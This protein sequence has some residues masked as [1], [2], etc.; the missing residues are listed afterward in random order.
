MAR[1]FKRKDDEEEK[2]RQQ[3]EAEEASSSS[4]S[5]PV[6]VGDSGAAD[7]VKHL[8]NVPESKKKWKDDTPP[9]AQA[10]PAA[11]PTP[12][13]APIEEPVIP[14]A[15]KPQ[16]F[17]AVKT[18]KNTYDFSWADD[19]SDQQRMVARIDMAH[20]P[21]MLAAYDD[22]ITGKGYVQDFQREEGEWEVLDRLKK[23]GLVDYTGKQYDLLHTDFSGLLN[24]VRMIPDTITR[25]AAYSDLKKLTKVK[26]GR[27]EEYT[28][29]GS[30]PGYLDTADMPE[31]DYD[32]FVKGVAGMFYRAGGYEKQN[33]KTYLK[34]YDEIT[35]ELSGLTDIQKHW[36]KKALDEAYREQT[37]LYPDVYEARKLAEGEKPQK[38]IS[39]PD[40]KPGRLESNGDTFSDILEWGKDLFGIGEEKPEPH[41][42]MPQAAP[43]PMG[44]PAPTPTPEPP[45]APE[46]QGPARQIPPTEEPDIILMEARRIGPKPESEPAAPE[47]QGP[48]QQEPAEPDPLTLDEQM[49]ARAAEKPEEPAKEQPA[50][51][52]VHLVDD[53]SGAIE[54]ARTG[55]YEQLDAATQ[56]E[57]QRFYDEAGP[58]TRIALGELAPELYKEYQTGNAPADYLYLQNAGMLGSTLAQYVLQIGGEDFPVELYGDAVMELARIT[59][60]AENDPTITPE[61]LQLDNRY[62]LYLRNHPDELA[63]LVNVFD[64]LAGMRSDAEANDVRLQELKAQELENARYAVSIGQANA[65]QKA[66]VLENAPDMDS[67]MAYRDRTYADMAQEL[68]E[69]FMDSSA[70]WGEDIGGWFNST[71][72]KM[73]RARGVKDLEDSESE[74]ELLLNN[75]ME[76]LLMQDMRMAAAV[77]Q[78]LETYYKKQGGMNLE[79]IAQRASAEILNIGAQTNEEELT[80]VSQSVAE[81]T[82]KVGLGVKNTVELTAMSG[83]GQV[84]EGALETV[85]MVASATDTPRDVA[86]TTTDF[87][88]LYGPFYGPT[89]CAKQQR[90]LAESGKLPE[91][92]SKSIIEYLDNGGDPYQLGIHPED[93]GGTINA[94]AETQ[95]R[96][97]YYQQMVESYATEGEAKFFE[98]GSGTV[99]NG[100]LMTA[101]AIGSAVLGPAA[102]GAAPFLAM[103]GTYGV[104][105]QGSYMQ[106][107]MSKGYTLKESLALSEAKVSS[108]ALAN[109]VSLGHLSGQLA[110]YSAWLNKGLTKLGGAKNPSVIRTFYESAKRFAVPLAKDLA[111]EVVKDPILEG[112][113]GEAA[114][115]AVATVIEDQREGKEIG[116]GTAVRAAVTGVLAG[117]ESV[118]GTIEAT[119]EDAPNA[120][121]ATLPIALLGAG[122]EYIKGSDSYKAAQNLMNH[123]SAATAAQFSDA[124]TKDAQDERWVDAI[125]AE[126]KQAEIEQTAAANLVFSPEPTLYNKAQKTREQAN[127]HK[128]TLDASTAANKQ[129]V[130]TIVEMQ[131]KLDAGDV[132]PQTVVELNNAQEAFAKSRHN[133]DESTREYTQKSTEARQAEHD[134]IQDAHD[135][136]VLEVNQKHAAAKEAAQVAVDMSQYEMLTGDDTLRKVNLEEN[137]RA[138]GFVNKREEFAD[139]IDSWDGEQK[140]LEFV[141]GRVSEPLKSVGVQDAEIVL[142]SDKLAKIKKDHPAM[143]DEVIRQLPEVLEKPVVV[144]KSRAV[145]G[146]LTMFGE[147]M[148]DAG[149]PVLAVVSLDP[150]KNLVAGANFIR[151]NSAYGKNTYPQEFINKSEILY[152]DKKRAADWAVSTGLQLPVDLTPVRDSSANIVPQNRKNDNPDIEADYRGVDGEALQPTPTPGQARRNPVQTL[153]RLS[154]DLG[155]GQAMGTKKM[156][157]LPNGVA[158]YYQRGAQYLATRNNFGSSVEVTAHEIGH[159]VADRLGITG[160]DRMVGNLSRRFTA[161]YPPDQLPGE[162]FAEFFWRYMVSDEAARDFAGDAFVADMER[163]LRQERMLKPVQK[164]QREIRRYLNAAT[165]EK[166]RLMIR[167]RSDKNR[168]LTIDERFADAERKFVTEFVDS[169]RPAEDVNDAIRAQTGKNRV[170]ERMNLRHSALM[171]STSP[172]RAWNLLT[173]NLTDVDGT[174]IGEGLKTRLKKTG[175]RGKDFGLLNEYMLAKHSLA[176]D[177]QGKPVFDRQSITGR[178]TREFIRET[179]RSHPEV[180]AAARAIQ[181]FRH[182]FMMA[183]MV[184]TGFMT[185]DTLNLFETMYPDYVPTYRVKDRGGRGAGGQTYQIRRAS[186]S[187]EEIVNPMDSFVEMV[188]TIVAMNL[189]NETAKTWDSVYRQYEGMGIFGREVTEDQ[190]VTIMN[191]EAT[192]EQVRRILEDDGTGDDVVQQVLDAIGTEQVRRSGTGDVNLP[193]IV[194]VQLP[195]GERR[196]YEMFDQELFDMLSGTEDSGKS[197]FDM[198]GKLTR[199]M[200]ALTTGSNPV[201]A[202]RNFMRDYQNSVNYG[203]WASNYA[204]GAYRWLHAAYNVWK[205][206][207]GYEQYAALGGGGWTQINPQNKRSA[208]EYRGELFEGY[209]T[210]NARRAGRWA[211]RK[212]WNTV[213]AARLNEIVEQASR[214]AE[215]KYG[216]HDLTTPEGRQEAYLAAQDVTTDFSRRGS[217]R[218]ARELRM[219][220]PFF[221]ASLQGIYRTGRQVTKAE[222]DRAPTR[223]IKTVINTGIAS[224]L[225][226]GLLLRHL[227]DDEKEE[228]LWLSD[229]LKAKH[230]YLPNF[231]PDVL[232]DAPLIRIPLAQDPL[233]YAVHA[234]VTNTMWSGQGEEWAVALSAVADNILNTMNPVNSTTLDPLISMSTNKNWYGSNI[235]P[236]SMDGWYVTNQYAETTPTAFVTASNVLDG[237]GVGISPMMLQYLAEQYTGYIGQ[238]AIPFFSKDEHTGEIEGVSA[239]IEKVRKT[240]TSDPLIS[241][242]VI[243]SVYDNAELLTSVTK[244]G[245]NNRPMDMLR[246]GLTQYEAS[247]AYEEAYDLMH[248]GGA[249]YEA[250]KFMKNGYKRIDEIEANPDLSED[251]KYELTSSIRREMIETA[252]DA[253]EEMAAF[254][255]RYLDGETFLGRFMKG[256]MMD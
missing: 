150:Q 34:K 28:L 91:E 192:Q 255:E 124:L 207:G 39:K 183:Y 132:D 171:Q 17:G 64:Q 42:P 120:F 198:L 169:T 184:D 12:A 33:A 30:D 46:V 119:I 200:S 22:Y 194:S 244:A 75:T 212:I 147:V 79:L 189:R 214:F 218:A 92:L 173:R 131:E 38:R 47:A 130:E 251:E 222:S 149:A 112:V 82:E 237:F 9:T 238:M 201:F 145:N 43:V 118:P 188:N 160:T 72:Y 62:E 158:G 14:E 143:S 234:A 59:T 121:V 236:R 104:V 204:Q 155:I 175:I 83:A 154:R 129:A 231:A 7:L 78:D 193:N 31:G 8:Q 70:N 57:L 20:D 61:D 100:I 40:D 97:E 52:S 230:M 109:M 162:A 157:N 2:K 168:D 139:A 93:L 254:R 128:A 144:M 41:G 159:A 148:D 18:G 87:N 216:E 242:Q 247:A 219:V 90:A 5:A 223:F 114:T 177:R 67:V 191:M 215:Y 161:N 111:E 246:S 105:S 127:S 240:L 220:V 205:E 133:I 115:S 197:A 248:A 167:D 228:F 138:T 137:M 203:S 241:Q 195:N 106:D 226:S 116:L 55:R 58:G 50:V 49:A 32:K 81:E 142:S 53:M 48:V 174:N 11:T 196:F 227:D 176:R 163:R 107:F 10:A 94:Y 95:D 73:M 151:L 180:A 85:I 202:V 156:N 4:A 245:D 25:K 54:Y 217:S 209:N 36:Y 77:G 1:L 181:E 249:I 37:G 210:S 45:V 13:P 186:G 213:T 253:N 56:A 233:S 21:D 152:V 134:L 86:R 76:S 136:A 172:R 182:D 68:N 63:G 126:E 199:T 224:A 221:N 51:G 60:A 125:R 26:G 44:T 108:D 170:D 123:P 101:A 19:W 235:V 135:K 35:G 252:L 23:R 99:Y 69:W 206:N 208:E 122:G 74:Y 190:R 16:K 211:G 239:V 6:T 232:G 225:A 27:F 102:G 166:I 179:E 110:G 243:S 250:K 84:K 146:R 229:D 140:G 66:I 15:E 256:T 29:T 153:K 24:A 71:V 80:Q 113:I 88:K 185:A 98:L 103:R 178:D 117:V 65:Q 164:A 96:L 165:D 141:V 187:T 3:Q 89:V